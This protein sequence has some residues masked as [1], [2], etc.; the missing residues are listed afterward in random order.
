MS[1]VEKIRI[2]SFLMFFVPVLIS[3]IAC[4]NGKGQGDLFQSVR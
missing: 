2:F 4:L 3:V 1:F